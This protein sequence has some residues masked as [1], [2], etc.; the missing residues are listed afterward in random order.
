M[1]RLIPKGL[2][3]IIPTHLA[4]A[5]PPPSIRFGSTTIKGAIRREL[6]S[7]DTDSP[8]H[9]EAFFQQMS[10]VLTEKDRRVSQGPR[11]R[12][13][14]RDVADVRNSKTLSWILRHGAKSEGIA[15]RPDGYVKVADLVSLLDSSFKF[16]SRNIIRALKAPEPQT[17]RP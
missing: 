13:L 6:R 11:K 9:P 14:D 16:F 7:L 8:D 5:T 12:G 10:K 4:R 2:I 1:L 15:M 17:G 3:S